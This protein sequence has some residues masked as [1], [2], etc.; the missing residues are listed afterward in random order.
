[1]TTFW[2]TLIAVALPV[3]A[4]AAAW[5]SKYTSPRTRALR[6][7]N[8]EIATL[9]TL[10]SE[11][12]S[13][14]EMEVVVHRHVSEYARAVT[15]DRS[16]TNRT[17]ARSMNIGLIIGLIGTV[18]GGSASSSVAYR[19]GQDDSTPLYVA[20][21][22]VSVLCTAF[23]VLMLIVVFLGVL[24]GAAALAWAELT[25]DEPIEVDPATNQS[26]S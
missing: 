4:G 12:P 6:L 7:L 5:V 17:R 20:A 22:L 23:G 18:G 11:R 21:L 2:T 16:G 9:N 10:P 13:Y 8:D 14:S 24:N 15:R 25:S 3:V 19:I 1:M 26:Q